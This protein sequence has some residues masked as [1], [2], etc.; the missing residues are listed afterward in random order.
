VQT[1]RLADPFEPLNSSLA[2]SAESYGVGKATENC[3]FLAEIKVRTYHTSVLKLL[4]NLL[5]NN[6]RNTME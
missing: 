5:T 3:C 4:S 6:C 1:R 2:Q